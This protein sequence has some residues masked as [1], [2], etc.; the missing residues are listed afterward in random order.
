MSVGGGSGERETRHD[1]SVLRREGGQYVN[2]AVPCSAKAVRGGLAVHRCKREDPGDD[3]SGTS[4]ASQG[5]VECKECS[6][7]F[8][9]PG[10]L[11]RHKCRRERSKPVQEQR[12]AL[13]CVTCMRWFKS[14]GGLSRH[15]SKIHGNN[16]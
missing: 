10:D 16:S 5:Q 8:S 13:Q 12:G 15:K 3:S 11:K 4:E 1:T 2:R 7:A 6:R 9:R 14:A